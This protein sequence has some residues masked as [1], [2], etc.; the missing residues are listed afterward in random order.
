MP[1][2]RQKLGGKKVVV[3]VA[4]FCFCSVSSSNVAIPTAFFREASNTNFS[5]ARRETKN[6]SR[7]G[8]FCL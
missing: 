7:N 2:K 1:A 4:G 3:D 8:N 5:S 6:N